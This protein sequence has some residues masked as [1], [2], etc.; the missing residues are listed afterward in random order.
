[1][2]LGKIKDKGGKLKD[3]SGGT[4]DAALEKVN[5]LLDEFN[6]AIPTIKALGFSV[7]NFHVGMGAIP[8]IEAKITGSVDAIDAEKIQELIQNNQDKQI[9]ITILQGL[10]TASHAKEQLGELAFKGVEVDIK[11]GLPPKISISFME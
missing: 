10:Q 6:K 3:I 1:M 5:H 4:A 9:L 8:E 7:N 11:L 2:D